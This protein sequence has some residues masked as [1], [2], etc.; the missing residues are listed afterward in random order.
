VNKPLKIWKSYADQLS[1]LE[2]RGLYIGDR[3]KAI[4]Y[5]DRIGYYR[6][7]G[8]WYPFRQV[9]SSTQKKL[10]QFIQDCSFEQ[11]VKLY[12]FDK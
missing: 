3:S 6:L 8:Y 5:L 4:D 7:S 12:I 11:A 10:D 2:Q 1:L 9:E